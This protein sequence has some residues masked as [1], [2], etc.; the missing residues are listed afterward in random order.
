MNDEVRGFGT[1]IITKTRNVYNTVNVSEFYINEGR[2]IFLLVRWNFGKQD[3]NVNIRTIAVEQDLL[4]K[5]VFEKRFAC[6]VNRWADI[7]EQN[8]RGF[9]E[10]ADEPLCINYK[11]NVRLRGSCLLVIRK[12][13]PPIHLVEDEMILK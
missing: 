11:C 4:V 12:N 3:I 6:E 13:L 8:A 5:N 10:A 7:R 9:R 1:I 2:F